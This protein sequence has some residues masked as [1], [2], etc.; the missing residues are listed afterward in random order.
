M[1]KK[2]KSLPS[3]SNLTIECSTTKPFHAS[4]N[5]IEQYKLC[6]QPF[7]PFQL[8]LVLI[9][10]LLNGF[11]CEKENREKMIHPRDEETDYSDDFKKYFLITNSISFTEA[12]REA[13]L[14]CCYFLMGIRALASRRTLEKLSK[15]TV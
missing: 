4:D 2:E 15:I 12:R 14:C 3:E 11:A 6:F 9:S 10:I 1:E 13:A 7:P 8:G 5:D